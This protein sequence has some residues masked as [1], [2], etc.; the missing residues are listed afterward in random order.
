[1][2][3]ILN[4]LKS[5]VVYF[6]YASIPVFLI[7]YLLIYTDISVWWYIAGSFLLAFIYRPYLNLLRLRALGDTKKYSVPYVIFILG[8]KYYSKIHFGTTQ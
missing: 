2:K 4:S 5:P 1:M 6:I 3:A 8:F 7:T